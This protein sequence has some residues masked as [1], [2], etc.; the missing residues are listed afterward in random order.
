MW[1][2][3]GVA[4]PGWSED[5]LLINSDPGWL[6]VLA[7]CWTFRPNAY[8]VP[9]LVET[10]CPHHCHFGRP[11]SQHWCY[12]LCGISL[13][14]GWAKLFCFRSKFWK[15]RAIRCIAT[16]FYAMQHTKPS[17]ILWTSPKFTVLAGPLCKSSMGWA[18]APLHWTSGIMLHVFRL[19]GYLI[20][21]CIGCM[22]VC[23]LPLLQVSVVTYGGKGTSKLL[24]R[25]TGNVGKTLV[26][27]C[28]PS[29]GNDTRNTSCQL[30]EWA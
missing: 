4:L 2:C 1:R 24:L 11:G 12:T 6:L 7:S 25:G 15:K 19:F 27:I 3:V 8:A 29:D 18:F 20:R 9:M 16:S 13:S 5:A 23:D 17:V 14:I 30:S 26:S 21:Y 10:I 22:C 28:C